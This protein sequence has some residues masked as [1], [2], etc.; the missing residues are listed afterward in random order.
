MPNVQT[1]VIRK[2]K[3]LPLPAWVVTFTFLVNLLRE[4]NLMAELSRRCAIPRQGGYGGFD[5]L[6]AGLAFFSAPQTG[7]I[8]GF[9]RA[10]AFTTPR[11]IPTSDLSVAHA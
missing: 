8:K 10:Y 11:P 1:V 9:G 3:L 5:L 2:R 6:I 4:G 7:G